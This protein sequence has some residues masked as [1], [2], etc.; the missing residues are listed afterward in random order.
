MLIDAAAAPLAGIYGQ[1]YQ[2]LL[3]M[4]QSNA[5]TMWR[6][7]RAE[8]MLKRVNEAVA[9]LDA[10]T[11]KELEIAV[12]R[13]Y[14]SFG[15]ASIEDLH[16]GGEIKDK[17][18]PLQ[19][20]QPHLEAAQAMANEAY[21]KFGHTMQG[22][23]RSAEEY[24]NL[25]QQ[26]AIRARIGAGT[27]TGETAEAIAKDVKENINQQGITAFIDKS[28]KRWQLD[29]YATMLTRT[30]LAGASRGATINLANEYDYDLV[31]VTRHGST[32]KECLVWEGKILSLNGK[33][34]QYPS[35]ED[36]K[37]EG[38]FHVN[39]RHGFAIWVDAAA[40]RPR[41]ISSIQLDN[42]MNVP[43]HKHEVFRA[44][45]T[46]ERKEIAGAK[47]LQPSTYEGRVYMAPFKELALQGAVGQ[48]SQFLRGGSPELIRF[49]ESDLPKN[50]HKDNHMPNGVPSFF[51]EEKVK[52]RKAE[53]S[54]DEGLTWKPLID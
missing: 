25:A 44:V 48:D 3:G 11:K 31:K 43:L 1:A 53:Y 5:S 22:M 49:Y 28:G 13:I 6:K 18:F 35:I 8:V 12:P 51:A 40:I 23:Q 9:K 34:K 54:T 16:I 46:D 17:D 41:E 7:E 36:A 38:L 4:L 37:Y 47:A 32:H 29:V 26:D 24:I 27:L 21:L 14:K 42:G 33:N 10:A 2:Q 52:L 39:C 15:Y 30:S 19:L 50:L 45:S 20:G